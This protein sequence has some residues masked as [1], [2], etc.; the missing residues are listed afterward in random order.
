L[1]CR[2]LSQ[3]ASVLSDSAQYVVDFLKRQKLLATKIDAII[4]V[5]E[6]ATALGNEISRMLIARKQLT[7]D[8]L[9]FVRVK[10]KSHGDPA[11]RFWT[12]GNVPKRVILLEDVTTTGGSAVDLIKNLR[13]SGV[14]V[15]AIIG[16][17]NY[18]YRVNSKTVLENFA[19]V[20]VPY[21]SLTTARKLLPLFIKTFSKK[22]GAEVLGII[23]AEGHFA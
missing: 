19:E 5:P 20:G 3:S 13:E 4:G 15:V 22:K 6:G 23:Q 2:R 9:Y 14:K 8:R 18:E 1:N 17:L 16:L 21:Y 11:N 7:S 12:N 10:P